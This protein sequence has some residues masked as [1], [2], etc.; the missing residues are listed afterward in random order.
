MEVNCNL[1]RSNDYK[2]FAKIKNFKMPFSIV[3]C[4]RCGLV[5]QNPQLDKEYIKSIYIEDYYLGKGDVNYS[6]DP[7]KDKFIADERFKII[8]KMKSP[9]KILDIGCHLGRFLEVAYKRG[10][11]PYGID[12][13]A[14]ATKE[15]DKIN[16]LN[17]FLGEL[18]E[19]RFE[20]RFFDL[21]TCF[22]V[23]EHFSYPSETLAEIH[24]IL[25]DDGLLV[26]Q[27]A[28]MNSFRIRFLNPHY[29]YL[30]V[31][32]YYFTKETIVKMLKNS[33]FKILKIF[34]GSEFN[35]YTEWKLFKGDVPIFRILLRKIL[36]R[37]EIG[38][39]TFNTTMVIYAKKDERSYTYQ[40][41]CY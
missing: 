6:K 5:Y 31:H 2:L 1:C 28:N 15:A 36:N 17:I 13:S 22:E 23:V 26:I 34:N 18:V 32:M 4:N 14:A 39:L 35:I 25:K 33:G 11:K 20:D 24:R 10:W 9:S 40:D 37:A 21:I 19:I 7:G 29:Y 41:T 16:G 30:P 38:N 3:K 27:T 8:E 12:I